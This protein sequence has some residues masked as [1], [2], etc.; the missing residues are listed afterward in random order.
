MNII[1]SQNL[2]RT[3]V[4]FPY[5]IIQQSFNLILCFELDD[6]DT[7]TL[8]YIVLWLKHQHLFNILPFYPFSLPHL[9]LLFVIFCY[10]C[11]RCCLVKVGATL[12]FSNNWRYFSRKLKMS[13]FP[14][15]C[16][17]QILQYLNF[18]YLFWYFDDV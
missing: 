1:K 11:F 10:S 6:N 12:T 9:F 17:Y 8:C 15:P 2:I 3:F 13:L 18:I 14:S 7:I 4:G 5:W 16:Y